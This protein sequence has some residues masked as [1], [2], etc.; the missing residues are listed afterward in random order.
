[1]NCWLLRNTYLRG[2]WTFL[3]I[4]YSRKRRL[5]FLRYFVLSLEHEQK[6]ERQFKNALLWKKRFTTASDGH[7]KFFVKK[8]RPGRSQKDLK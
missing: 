5:P 3:P 7:E 6:S 8:N 1:M 4:R 2:C